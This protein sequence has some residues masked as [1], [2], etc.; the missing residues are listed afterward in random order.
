MLKIDQHTRNDCAVRIGLEAIVAIFSPRFYRVAC[1]R[2]NF[3]KELQVE[4]N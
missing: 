4:T 2:V 1:A 3:K